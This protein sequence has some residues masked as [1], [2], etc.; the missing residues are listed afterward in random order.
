MLLLRDLGMVLVLAC[1]IGVTTRE[2]VRTAHE[3]WQRLEAMIESFHAQGSK[4]PVQ[5][6]EAE[7]PAPTGKEDEA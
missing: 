6:E 5:S 1:T 4:P 3:L 7:P 2:T